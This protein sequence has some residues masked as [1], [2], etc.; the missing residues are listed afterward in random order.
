MSI[1]TLANKLP[2]WHFHHDYMVF[3]DG[4]LGLGFKIDGADISS[5]SNETINNLSKKFET[6]LVSLDE[7]MKIQLVYDV[8]ANIESIWMHIKVH[9]LNQ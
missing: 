3:M 5:A 6:L 1:N 2:Y 4:S 9:L 7:G 8:K